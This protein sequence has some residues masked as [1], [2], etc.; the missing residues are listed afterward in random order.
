MKYGGISIL[1]LG[2]MAPGLWGQSSDEAKARRAKINE[3]RKQVEGSDES[4]KTSALA[5]L[6]GIND[7]EARSLIASKLYKDTD[8]VRT[9]AAKAIARQRRSSSAGALGRAIQAS[10]TNDRML[11]VYVDALA[12][13]DMCSGIGP[14]VMVVEVKPALAGDALA[15]I[16]KIGCPDAIPMLLRSLPRAE[17]EEKKPDRFE[18][19][20]FGG[21]GLPGTGGGGL[22]G[23]GGN[24]VGEEENR[25]KNKPLAAAAG[26]MREAM[27]RLAGKSF[28]NAQQWSAGLSSGQVRVKKAS[29]YLCEK[30]M[31]TYD[32]PSDKTPKCPNPDPSMKSMH[33]DIFLKHKKE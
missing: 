13:L 7:D 15:A 31:Q 12:E 21:G 25:N 10:L 2:L 28:P 4:A 11:K 5:E 1:V 8:N 22:P 17:A 18:G 30:T 23:T 9:A 3:L 27:S 6:G 24:G 16:E 33:E 14:L 29:L 32:V 20:S 26:R 19:A